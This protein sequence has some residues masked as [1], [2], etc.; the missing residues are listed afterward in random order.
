MVFILKKQRLCLCFVQIDKA[1]EIMGYWL[2]LE[3]L[4]LILRFNP[5]LMAV[6]LGALACWGMMRRKDT[7]KNR[8]NFFVAFTIW[9]ITGFVFGVLEFYK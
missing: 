6:N 3:F 8:R 1:V 2:G 5:V 4:A 7:T 9:C